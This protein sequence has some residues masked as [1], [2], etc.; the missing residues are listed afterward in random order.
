VSIHRQQIKH[1]NGSKA[2]D[3]G[4]NPNRPKNILE[5]Q[6]KLPVR[7]VTLIGFLIAH[8]RPHGFCTIHLISIKL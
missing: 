5:R 1:D 2:E 3:H 8:G 7:G 6:A 4:K